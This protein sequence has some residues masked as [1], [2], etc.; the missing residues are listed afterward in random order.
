MQ[1]ENTN[2][3]S[4]HLSDDTVESFLLSD[5]NF[6]ER[7][8]QLLA[9]LHLPSP[10]GNGTISLIQRQQIA[11]RDKIRATEIIMAEMM[12]YGREND[13]TSQKIHDLSLALL[14]NASSGNLANILEQSIKQA[15]SLAHISLH[16]WDSTQEELS[17]SPF[18]YPITKEFTQWMTSLTTP[19]HGKKNTAVEILIDQ[20][21]LNDQLKS[22]ALIPLFNK[23]SSEY[24]VY[25]AI[26]LASND[27]EQFHNDSGKL[28]LTRIGELISAA[29]LQNLAI[30]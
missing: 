21:I 2:I 30:K 25:G 6:F 29:L 12:E 20:S 22:F 28:F 26:I 19:Y 23:N 4:N 5:P 7:N 18:F 14:A 1:Q 17:N 15:F 3:E 13:I 11:Q 9:N 24:P 16:V 10:H 27:Q 8:A